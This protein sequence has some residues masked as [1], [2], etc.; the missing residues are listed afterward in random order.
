MKTKIMSLY[1]FFF[2]ETKRKYMIM[3]DK[4]NLLKTKKYNEKENKKHLYKYF[5]Y[6][7]TLNIILYIINK[8]I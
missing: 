7:L 5:C 1:Q 6:L 4:Y 3:W 2:F 8:N